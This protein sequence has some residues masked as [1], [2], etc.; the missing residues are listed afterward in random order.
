MLHN[1]LVLN[2]TLRKLKLVLIGVVMSC[3]INSAFRHEILLFAAYS[4][5]D[6]AKNS[7]VIVGLASW[8][9]KG[10]DHFFSWSGWETS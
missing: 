5:L 1:E 9:Y 2:T 6:P 8:F 10:F 3:G 4:G 7:L